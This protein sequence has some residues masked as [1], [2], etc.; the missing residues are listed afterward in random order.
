MLLLVIHETFW[1]SF[2]IV[3]SC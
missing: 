2:Y 3:Y 1:C